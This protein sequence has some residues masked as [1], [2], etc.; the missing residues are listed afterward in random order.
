MGVRG[1]RHH[2]GVGAACTLLDGRHDQLH[3]NVWEWVEDCYKDS[4]AGAPTDGAAVTS[5]SCA[6]RIL[7]GGSWNYYPQLLRSAYRYATAG[8]IRLENAG[9]RVAR[10]L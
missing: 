3:G 7:R 1:T 9:F 6:L 10:A 2:Q 8:G 4:Y 5:A